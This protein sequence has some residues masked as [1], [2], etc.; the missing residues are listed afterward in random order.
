MRRVF[1]GERGA[2]NRTRTYT[3]QGYGL[4]RPARLPIPPSGQNGVYIACRQV[5][6]Q[7][8]SLLSSNS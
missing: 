2:R 4:L 7:V 8:L 1:G 6:C 3:P 5:I